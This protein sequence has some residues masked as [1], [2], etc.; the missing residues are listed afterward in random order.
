ME[1]NVIRLLIPVL[2]DLEVLSCRV[3]DRDLGAAK[4]AAE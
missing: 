4:S 3:S 2:L 1:A